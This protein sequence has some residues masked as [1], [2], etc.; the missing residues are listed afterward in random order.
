MKFFKRVG[1][2]VV[3][4]LTAGTATL[5]WLLSHPPGL[6]G[7]STLRWPT[8]PPAQVPLQV[9]FLGV[10]TVLLDDGETALLTDGF[11]SRPNKL[12]TFLRQVEP[13]VAGIAAGLQRAG[14]PARTGTLA[15]VIPLHSHYDHAMDA[16]EVARRTGALLLGSSSTAM[17]GR[18]WGLAEAQ[19]RTAELGK[20]YRFGRFTV[21]LY[22]A[23]HT[24]TG[25][26]GGEITA[27]LKPPVRA[28]EYKEG[29]SYVAHITHDG[30]SLLIT[31]TAGYV[32][33]GLQGVKADVVLLG[34]GAMGPR[35]AEHKAA[36]W[37][38]TVATVGARR[39]IP[40]HWDDF[41]IPS[42][43]PM[44]PMPKPLD[45]FE[46]SMQFLQQQASQTKVDLRL[47]LEWQPMDIFANLPPVLK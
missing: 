24:P 28:T 3:L 42:T 21:T 31:G 20:P 33:G 22:P 10:A 36:Y 40:I 6:D 8:P 11:F 38:E 46:A 23:L 32:P 25:F 34:I 14:I 27:P 4:V 44:Q 17:V 39:V 13:D 41:W 15:A 19:I 5:A 1:A 16:P 12:T 37:Q 9:S 18:G 29:Q 43:L 2:V 45:D 26:T 7:L 30:R 35:S 47:P